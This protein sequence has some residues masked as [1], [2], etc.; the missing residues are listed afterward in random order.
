MLTQAPSSLL[1]SKGL[2]SF[3]SAAACTPQST[4]LERKQKRQR[5]QQERVNSSAKPAMVA[6]HDA[7]RRA[8]PA[9]A[10]SA[11]AAAA[12]A[13]K[14][15]APTAT[16]ARESAAS[17]A[18]A[19]ARPVCPPLPCP[20][21]CALQ[22]SSCQSTSPAAAAVAMVQS[23]AAAQTFRPLACKEQNDEAHLSLYE[24]QQ[25]QLL[26]LV[27]PKL[28]ATQERSALANLLQL[29][30][31]QQQ[32]LL[33]LPAAFRVPTMPFGL[34]LLMPALV[35]R[36]VLRPAAG[37]PVGCVAPEI[38]TPGLLT[39]PCGLTRQRQHVELLRA[40]ALL[41][42]SVTRPFSATRPG[43]C[44]MTTTPAAAAADA[45][46]EAGRHSSFC[47][48]HLLQLHLADAAAA[49]VSCAETTASSLAAAAK[50]AAAQ[51][52]GATSSAVLTAEAAPNHRPWVRAHGMHS[53]WQS[54]GLQG[55]RAFAA[56]VGGRACRQLLLELQEVRPFRVAVAAVARAVAFQHDVSKGSS[57]GVRRGREC[58]GDAPAFVES[59]VL[60]RGLHAYVFAGVERAAATFLEE[61]ARD[62]SSPTETRSPCVRDV[63]ACRLLS[64]LVRF[65]RASREIL[66]QQ[67]Q[68]SAFALKCAEEMLQLARCTS[69][70]SSS[71]P[72]TTIPVGPSHSG[73]PSG[74]EAVDLPNSRRLLLSLLR[75][76][77]ASMH[78]TSGGAKPHQKRA[79]FR[80][81]DVADAAREAARLQAFCLEDGHMQAAAPAA[82]AAATVGGDGSYDCGTASVI[83]P[84][85]VSDAHLHSGA[86]E[87]LLAAAALC[88]P[89]V[90]NIP[91]A[92]LAAILWA[93]AT[94]ASSPR[95]PQKRQEQQQLLQGQQRLLVQQQLSSLFQAA[96]A[97]LLLPQQNAQMLLQIREG[98]QEQQQKDQHPPQQEKHYSSPALQLQSS[99][100]L[101]QAAPLDKSLLTWSLLTW[102]RLAS[103][104][105]SAAATCSAA[106][107]AATSPLGAVEWLVLAASFQKQPQLQQKLLRSSGAM[108]L[109]ALA[110][111]ADELTRPGV[112]YAAAA[113]GPSSA[114]A[115]AAQANKQQEQTGPCCTLKANEAATAQ[116]AEARNSAALIALAALPL[117]RH[118]C[119]QLLRSMQKA[120]ASD[121]FKTASCSRLLSSLVHSAALLRRI[122]LQASPSAYGNSPS[123]LPG[124][125]VRPEV[126]MLIVQLLRQLYVAL[127]QQRPQQ[128]DV[129]SLCQIVWVM[130]ETGVTHALLLEHLQLQAEV[131]A[132]PSVHVA[133][134]STLPC[135][136][137]VALV[138]AVADTGEAVAFREAGQQPQQLQ[139][140]QQPHQQLQQMHRCL[141]RSFLHELVLRVIQQDGSCQQHQLSPFHLACC[142]RVSAAVALR[143]AVAALHTGQLMSIG[144]RKEEA[145]LAIHGQTVTERLLQISDFLPLLEKQQEQ[146]Q[147]Q[148]EEKQQELQEMQERQHLIQHTSSNGLPQQ[149]GVSFEAET[150][151]AEG[152]AVDFRVLSLPEQQQ[153]QENQR[154][155]QQQRIQQLRGHPH[156]QR[157]V[158]LILEVDGPSH[159]VTECS[160]V[161]DANLRLLPRG[162]TQLKEDLL[163]ILGWRVLRLH[164]DAASAA[165]AK[166][167]LLLLLTQEAGTPLCGSSN[168][169]SSNV[170]SNSSSGLIRRASDV[171]LNSRKSAGRWQRMHRSF[172][173]H[174][175]DFSQNL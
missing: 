152:L 162:S 7:T 88:T 16:T 81:R 146:R 138:F 75:W 131:P 167:Q 100:Q 104:S 26:L 64:A 90:A 50:A 74:D 47:Y 92:D 143:V 160:G 43:G 93:A 110:V 145:I 118:E 171:D 121:S 172:G 127:Q 51:P 151:T 46:A 150:Q 11:G 106:A 153:D 85:Q 166:R 130:A 19:P 5:H 68:M 65:L 56:F 28:R 25:E 33:L 78:V 144:E 109:H 114:H 87:V 67:Q 52:T 80:W 72:A 79:A 70:C 32:Q 54:V 39:S 117:V 31:K 161:S 8:S 156:Q 86:Q 69:G 94:S 3:A 137:A 116:G 158:R 83:D 61:M 1:P 164:A 111:K 128:Q 20:H 10:E 120:T 60:Q 71:N 41:L 38:E 58:C 73:I 30:A 34:A 35:L 139:Q 59:S 22:F 14:G 48:T 4:K 115:S 149:D 134:L 23:G 63:L 108:A 170:G 99:W 37:A 122:E 159:F 66:K 42:P 173:S 140:R 2:C 163:T 24:Q 17:D 98:R 147:Q 168:D 13:A 6:G 45:G 136:A 165:A 15:A 77:A 174:P 155:Q 142:L 135:R 36:A 21:C 76:F 154:Q 129:Q 27:Q 89:E 124:K 101:Q 44:A 102:A 29:N 141:V 55:A 157:E 123:R 57:S 132:T 113:A 112:V 126:T 175:F 62:R 91:P 133:E 105:V 9:P 103:K 40:Y 12:M 169:R 18:L 96:S 53:T 107:S 49:A 97:T 84:D 119:A 148:K 125:A 95:G 82:A